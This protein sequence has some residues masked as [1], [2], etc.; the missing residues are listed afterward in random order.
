LDISHILVWKKLVH[1]DL[2]DGI[3]LDTKSPKLD[4]I[5]YM[6]AKLFE[7]P[8]SPAT[9]METKVEELTHIDL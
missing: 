3:Q 4:C 6:E 8:Y 2:I 5:P 1:L 9:G 7:A